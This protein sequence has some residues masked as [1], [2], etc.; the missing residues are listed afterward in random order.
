MAKSAIRNEAFRHPEVS[1]WEKEF[2]D[3][4]R[5]GT[6]CPNHNVTQPEA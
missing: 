6:G 5:F 2:T 3:F 1:N 4:K